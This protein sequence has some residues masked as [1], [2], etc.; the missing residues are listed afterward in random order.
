MVNSKEKSTLHVYCWWNCH[1]DWLLWLVICLPIELVWTNI[2]PLSVRTAYIFLH[3]QELRFYWMP[4][5]FNY[6]NKIFIDSFSIIRRKFLQ[7]H[8]DSSSQVWFNHSSIHLTSLVHLISHHIWESIYIFIII[9][10]HLY[11]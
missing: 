9:P 1:L 7:N 3:I 4:F 6:L 11:T 2:K 8:F 10:M 5:L